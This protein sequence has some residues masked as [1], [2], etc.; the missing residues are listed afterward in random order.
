MESERW[1]RWGTALLYT[2]AITLNV[3]FLWDRVKD[4]PETQARM[5]QLKAWWAKLGEGCEG[6]KR[7]KAAINKMLF[8]ATTIVEE[9]RSGD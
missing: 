3:L 1:E 4:R 5:A 8:E 6:C 2:G 9:A 7:R